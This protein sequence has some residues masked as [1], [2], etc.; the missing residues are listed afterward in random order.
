MLE[1]TRPKVIKLWVFLL[2]IKVSYGKIL[3]DINMSKTFIPL[4]VYTSYSILKS[5]LTLE[6]YLKV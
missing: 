4:H 3:I 5:G 1:S 2:Q 6:D